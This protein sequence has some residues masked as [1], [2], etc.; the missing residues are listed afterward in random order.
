M[1]LTDYF[2]SEESQQWHYARQI[3][4]EHGVIR[5]PEDEQFDLT[6]ATH[7]QSVYD[8]FA[9]FGIRPIVI[10]PMPN[11]V[12]EHIKKGDG[13]REESIEKVIKMLPIM[14]R[15]D[16][17]TICFNFMAHIGWFRTTNNIVERG[18]ALVTGFDMDDYVTQD[19]YIISEPELWANLEYFL[20]AIMPHAKKHGIRLAL[21]PDDPPVPQLGGVSRILTS[22]DNINRA[23]HLVESDNLGVTLCQGSFGAMGEDLPRVIKTFAAQNKLFF[24]HFRDVVGENRYRFR[25]CFHDNGPTDMSAIIALYQSLGCE[26]V[27]IRIDHVPTMAGEDNT[28]PGYASL[29][30]LFAIGYLKG[31][32]EANRK[33]I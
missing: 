1:I 2:R 9:S 4:V 33:T 3:G 8:R 11:S 17:R 14:E 7:W 23:V 32:M 18:G 20:R 12:H 21:H 31:L 27:P 10:E 22:F 15:L 6:D 30:R 19:E 29:G 26:D 28:V 24:I 13:K 5:L 25:E 16:I